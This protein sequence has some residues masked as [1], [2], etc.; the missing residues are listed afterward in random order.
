MPSQDPHHKIVIISGGSAGISVAARPLNAG[1]SG[2][3]VIDPAESITTSPC[4]R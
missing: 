4:G 2:V 3:A 1:E